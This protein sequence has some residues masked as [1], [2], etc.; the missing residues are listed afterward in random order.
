MIVKQV[1]RLYRLPSLCL[2]LLVGLSACQ[3][4]PAKTYE[5][6]QRAFTYHA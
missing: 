6:R 2:L 1:H 5:V 3:T 4:I